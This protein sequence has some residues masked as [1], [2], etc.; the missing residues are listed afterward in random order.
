VH[1]ANDQHRPSVGLFGT[2]ATSSQATS[3]QVAE[4][5]GLNKRY[6]REW[7]NAGADRVADHVDPA[8]TSGAAGTPTSLVNGRRKEA[9]GAV[10]VALRALSGR[11]R[12]STLYRALR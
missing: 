11:S 7:L 9:E 5:G 6:V 12:A 3:A 10:L 2:L 8:G 4:A 1:C